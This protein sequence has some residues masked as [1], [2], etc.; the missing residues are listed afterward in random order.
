MTWCCYIFV[1]ALALLSAGPRVLAQS[2]RKVRTENLQNVLDTLTQPRAANAGNYCSS[3]ELTGGVHVLSTQM[4]FSNEL[5][6]LEILGPLDQDVFVECEFS[7]Q[8]N[9][10]WYFSGIT[11]LKIQNLHFR[12]CPTP[13][14]I[15]SASSIEITNCTFRLFTLMHCVSPS[16]VE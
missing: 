5:E 12:H 13:L 11:S 10:T 6:D 16:F 8:T 9:Y 15:D 7:V 14:R 1:T 4:F 2:C 3:I